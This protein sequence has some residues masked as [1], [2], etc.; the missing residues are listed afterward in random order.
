MLSSPSSELGITWGYD[1]N[2]IK[3]EFYYL[4]HWLHWLALSLEIYSSMA[5]NVLVLEF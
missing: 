4:M 2:T 1:L 3:L 5:L